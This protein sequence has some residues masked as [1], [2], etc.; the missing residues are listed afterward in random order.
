MI[1]TINLS[2]LL[3]VVDEAAKRPVDVSGGDF[4]LFEQSSGAG[5][6]LLLFNRLELEADISK[7][8][9]MDPTT[10]QI[11][12][13]S[14]LGFI[15]YGNPRNG[16]C[17]VEAVLS[18]VPGYGP[19]MYEFAMASIQRRLGEDQWFGSDM[20]VEERARSI[21]DK[22]LEGANP[23]IESQWAGNV[24]KQ[25]IIAA[26]RASGFKLA[27]FPNQLLTNPRGPMTEEQFMSDPELTALYKEAN[28]PGLFHVYRLRSGASA[29][30]VYNSL[31]AKTKQWALKEFGDPPDEA[32]DTLT[33]LAANIFNSVWNGAKQQ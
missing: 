10:Y 6:T 1:S 26:L 13:R 3:Y 4:L 28:H 9:S 17:R 24:S 12:R 25:A 31:A 7:W 33:N 8:S 18:L 20:S 15:Q 14:L 22:F 29:I 30:D 32:I 11:S 21:W 27:M 19:L 16:V 23:D 5:S 2:E